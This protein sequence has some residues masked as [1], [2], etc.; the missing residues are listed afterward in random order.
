MNMFQLGCQFLIKLSGENS[1]ETVREGIEYSIWQSIKH[2]ANINYKKEKK[3]FF[4]LLT[5]WVDT[6]C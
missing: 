5:M 3:L 1:I 2:T 6:H 4:E